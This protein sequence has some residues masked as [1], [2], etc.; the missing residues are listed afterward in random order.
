MLYD[1]HAQT[2]LSDGDL[3]PV[4]Q[5]RRAVVNGYAVVG[6][7]DHSGLADSEHILKSLVAACET[8]QRFWNII[9]IPGVELTHLPPAAI[10]PT[11]PKPGPRR[12]RPEAS[13]ACARE[14]AE[15]G[16]N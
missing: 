8:A 10:P 13:W 16:R 3:S 7:T 2:T 9:A 6:L 14:A 1:F 12:P 11:P 5:I 4:E 15:R